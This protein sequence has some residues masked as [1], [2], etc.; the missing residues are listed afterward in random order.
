[1]NDFYK[2]KLTT[3][4]E[5][6]KLVRSGD[7]VFL[8]QTTAF[9]IDLMDAL[10]ERRNE[11]ENVTIL[12]GSCVMPNKLM[13]EKYEGHNPFRLVSFFYGPAERAAI[14]NGMPADYT[15]LHLSKLSR[16]FEEVG[17]PDV[18]FMETSRPDENGMAVYSPSGLGAYGFAIKNAR[19]IIVEANAKTPHVQGL[20][21]MFD[22]RRADAIVETDNYRNAVTLTEVDEFS[23]RIARQILD[24][25]HD[26]DTVQFGVGRI[27]DAVGYGLR[28][29]NDLGI[30]SEFFCDSM[31]KL[32]KNGNV[33]NKYKGYMD[34]KTVFC[35]A[36]GSKELYQYMDYND[37]LYAGTFDSVC[38]AANIGKNKNLKSINTALAIDL[39]GQVAAENLRGNQYS[40]TGGQ[41]DFVRGA[42]ISEGGHSFICIEST[43]QSKKGLVSKISLAL[44]PLTPVT[45]PRQDVEYVVTE[46]GCV[47]LMSKTMKERAAALISIAHPDFR[48]QL[49]EDAKKAGLL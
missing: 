12:T 9:C 2:S 32:M 38:D 30:H 43:A 5:A 27:P 22:L 28:E 20:D 19:N 48:D 29:K 14:S 16:W 7:R 49:T 31:V 40:A 1:M 46:Y 25:I 34:G 10:Y 36:A 21:T 45:T 8:G 37:A 35:F 26:G 17:K 47:N 11:L 15:S 33:T 23:K 13:M 42:H 6:V 41:L 39:Y 4:Q 18:V 3:P 24:Y 44:P